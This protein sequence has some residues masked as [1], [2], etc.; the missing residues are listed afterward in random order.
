[1]QIPKNGLFSIFCEPMHKYYII[2]IVIFSPTLDL[3]MQTT[4]FK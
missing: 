2:V 1:M 4:L 3:T